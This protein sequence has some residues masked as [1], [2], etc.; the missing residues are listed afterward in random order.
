[1]DVTD[2]LRGFSLEF[3]QNID[4]EGSYSPGNVDASGAGLVKW[5][6]D[7]IYGSDAQKLFL[8]CKFVQNHAAGSNWVETIRSEFN[9][10]TEN[11]FQLVVLHPAPETA[12]TT[13]DSYYGFSIIFEARPV[14]GTWEEENNGFGER[15]VNARWEAVYDTTESIGWSMAWGTGIS[16]QLGA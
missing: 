7:W 12:G 14:P 6:D 10:N 8:Q 16:T 15:F 13:D 4:E 2:A 1:V 9:N 5:N 3:E 11:G